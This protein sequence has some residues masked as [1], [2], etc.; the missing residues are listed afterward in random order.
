MKRA[1]LVIAGFIIVGLTITLSAP[2][3]IEWMER[4]T[5]IARQEGVEIP[6]VQER[7]SSSVTSA[8]VRTAVNW[9]VPFTSQA[10]LGV[11]DPD[12]K[13][14]CEEASIL[15]VL[16]YFE[17]RPFAS[18]E[19]ADLA[20]I[21]LVRANENLGFAVDTTA[22]EVRTLLLSQNPD[23][24]AELLHD[25]SVDDLKRVL[26]DGKLVIVPAQGQ[27]LGNPYFQNPGP[28]YHMLVLRGFT[29]DGM[30]ITNDPGT[31]RGE[32]F[33]YSW[34]T[35]MYALHDWNGG[36]VESGEKVVVVVGT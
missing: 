4:R 18:P 10:P 14:A 20:L 6:P 34:D 13:E 9:D 31:R 17:G 16:R 30:V 25:P 29:D 28:P 33:A 32:Q 2:S 36:E 22:A 35:L 11:W 3:A 26:S 24:S 15:M 1:I 7:V 12:H 19:E 8:D 23:F 21:A 5:A 27:F